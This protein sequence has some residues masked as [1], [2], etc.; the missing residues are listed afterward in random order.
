MGYHCTDN[1][2]AQQLLALLFGVL[3]LLNVTNVQ[4][5]IAVKTESHQ[6]QCIKLLWAHR[7]FKAGKYPG[8]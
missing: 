3:F 7:S 5:E 2:I 1:S 4:H 8:I 6:L